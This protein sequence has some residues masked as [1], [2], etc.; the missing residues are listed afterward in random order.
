[1][2]R[3]VR[4]DDGA[5]VTA[6]TVARLL[7]EIGADYTARPV[8]RDQF[9]GTRRENVLGAQGDAPLVSGLEDTDMTQ[10]A[11]RDEATP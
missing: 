3:A 8:P 2:F 6:P 5:A 1:M 11:D 10:P 9:S 4:R 7:A